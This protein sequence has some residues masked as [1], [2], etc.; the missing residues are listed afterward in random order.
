MPSEVAQTFPVQKRSRNDDGYILTSCI[1][2]GL[3]F[4]EFLANTCSAPEIFVLHT[5][6]LGMNPSD[7]FYV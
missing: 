6:I 1:Y 7:S 3:R 2:R 4:R 5:C